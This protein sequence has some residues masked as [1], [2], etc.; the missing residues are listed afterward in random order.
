[1][2]RIKLA[3]ENAKKTYPDGTANFDEDHAEKKLSS[4]PVSVRSHQDLRNLIKAIIAAVLI[5]AGTVTWLRL[6]FMNQMEQGASEQI[7]EGIE[8]ARVEAKRRLEYEANIKKL[9]DENFMHC[10]DAAQKARNDYIQLAQEAVRIRNG[11]VMHGQQ[12]KFYIPKTALQEANSVMEQAKA[13]CQ[14]V[15]EASLQGGK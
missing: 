13:K 11:K 8:Q 12:E 15:Y 3:I 6:D 2:E 1:M 9:A 14:Q 7:H 5:F 4:R 10:K